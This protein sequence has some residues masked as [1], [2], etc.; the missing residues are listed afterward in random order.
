MAGDEQQNGGILRL[1]S[2]FFGVDDSSFVQSSEI[3]VIPR[4]E[5]GMPFYIF[6]SL[7]I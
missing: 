2:F 3:I 5:G 1:V 6:S 7:F 4:E